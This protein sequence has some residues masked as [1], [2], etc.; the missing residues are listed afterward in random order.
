MSLSCGWYVRCGLS[1]ARTVFTNRGCEAEG[2]D[3]EL[4][5]PKE[6]FNYEL[7]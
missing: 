1:S 5:L 3:N 4:L 2:W 7:Y 6:N